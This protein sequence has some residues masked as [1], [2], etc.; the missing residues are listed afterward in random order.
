MDINRI[1]YNMMKFFNILFSLYESLIRNISG[2]LG[3]RIRYYYY[4]NRFKSCGSNV[5]ID[6]GVVFHNCENISIGNDVWIMSYSILTAR[7]KG[8]S[9]NNR[10]IKNK[11]NNN[12][13][14]E[15]GEL[16]IENEVSIGN[17]NIIQAY[18]GIV[19]GNKVTTSARVSIYSFSH[20]PFDENDLS[21][22]TYANAMVNST[23]ISCI[24]SPI[25]IK[26][27]VWLALNVIVFGGT[28]GS[29]SFVST[30]SVILHDYED[31]SYIS[32]SPAK[33]IKNR[34]KKNLI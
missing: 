13:N 33:R 10:I 31:N 23:N 29:N 2:S 6:L 25:V 19:I 22:I 8:L 12:F 15:I 7:P 27:G 24:Q 34:F 18:G 1:K 28:I 9:I 16:I 30:N 26:E 14:H 17:Y 20:Y 5:R 21:K 11:I 32:G 3:Q 4:K